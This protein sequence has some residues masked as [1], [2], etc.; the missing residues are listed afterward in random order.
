MVINSYDLL[1][2]VCDDKK[3]RK[4]VAGPLVEVRNGL[5]DGLF[6]VSSKASTVRLLCINRIVFDRPSLTNLTGLSL[7]RSPASLFT[8]LTTIIRM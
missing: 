1:K 3:F 5:G 4:T 2:D 6:T 8:A 7:V